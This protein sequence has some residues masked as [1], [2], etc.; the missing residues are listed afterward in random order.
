M[1]RQTKGCEFTF[2]HANFTATIYGQNLHNYL[3]L[4]RSRDVI[5]HN[6]LMTTWYPYTICYRCSIVTE[7]VSPTVCE[8]L[9]PK[10]IG[11][12]THVTS[13]ITWRFD[14][15]Y[16]ISYWCFI[17]TE[18]LSPSVWK[19]FGSKYTWVTTLT[20]LGHVTSLSMWP[21]DTPYSIFYR[22]SI[23]TDSISSRFRDFW[24]L[25]ILGSRTWPFK[26]MWRHRSRDDSI[27]HIW[28]QIYRGHDLDLLGSRYVIGHVTIWC[29]IEDFL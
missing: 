19:L 2:F 24:A 5:E 3:I 1:Q 14:S 22:R 7:S 21:F 8:I 13:L 12:T 9:G 29:P 4:A 28:L 23:V 15:P 6:F 20:F 18:L 17:E 25:N 26:V 16:A 10:H 11:V 27:P